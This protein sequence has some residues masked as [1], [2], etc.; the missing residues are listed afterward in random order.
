MIPGNRVAYKYIIDKVLE[1]TEEM[2]A[3]LCVT[4]RKSKTICDTDTCGIGMAALVTSY[5]GLPILLGLAQPRLECRSS[6]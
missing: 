1:Y 6:P 4:A 5:A 2:I 3:L